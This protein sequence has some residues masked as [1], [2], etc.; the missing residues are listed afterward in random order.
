MSC[1]GSQRQAFAA[2]PSQRRLNRASTLVSAAIPVSTTD[3]AAPSAA[4]AQFQYRGSSAL[5]VQNPDNGHRYE[6][7]AP[8]AVVLADVADAAWLASFPW[9]NRVR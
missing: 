5:K 4:A 9:L 3:A 8:G 1:C 6:F 2:T 7:A